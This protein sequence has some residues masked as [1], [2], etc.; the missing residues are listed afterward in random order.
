MASVQ[1]M[2]QQ[3]SRLLGAL[4]HLDLR[5]KTVVIFF[6]DPGIILANMTAGQKQAY[7]RDLFAFAYTISYAGS[8][9]NDRWRYTRW[10]DKG[11][12]LNEELHDHK[13]DPE[14]LVNLAKEED[15]EAILIKMRRKFESY[16]TKARKTKI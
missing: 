1:F 16:R 10:G 15:Y 7:G 13:N 4:D 2:Y 8:L 14:E 3:V 5:N 12:T 11:T 6:S 9:R